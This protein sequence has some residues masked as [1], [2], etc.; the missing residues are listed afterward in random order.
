MLGAEEDV[1]GMTWAG[2]DPRSATMT[3]P[4]SREPS[5]PRRTSH[6]S[7][8]IARDEPLLRPNR[9][10]FAFD[11]GTARRRGEPGRPA[12]LPVPSLAHRAGARRYLHAMP[13][14]TVGP[15]LPMPTDRTPAPGHRSRDRRPIVRPTSGLF[16]IAVAVLGAACTPVE[17]I[18][19]P[20][21][22]QAST[23][24]AVTPSLLK[25]RAWLV[26]SF[27]NATQSAADPDF[28]S[29]DLHVVPIWTSRRDG[30]WLYVEQ[31]VTE[32]PARP[33]RQQVHRLLPMHATNGRDAVT[34][35]VFTL[36]GDPIAFAGAWR[37]P[38]AFDEITPEELEMLEGCGVTF[39]LD[40]LER[41]RGSTL[42][43]NCASSLGDAV[44]ITTEVELF[45][46]RLETLERGYDA[47]G[48]QVWGS[49]HGPYRLDRVGRPSASE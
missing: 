4:K 22:D 47:D 24:T 14:K 40:G 5:E 13:I 8:S 44:Y 7:G 18:D 37:T 21:S 36:P 35:L 2:I 33:Y 12:P 32:A 41:I 9:D 48:E 29:I 38:E 42:G 39:E 45:R 28:R 3:V 20:P 6:A 1:N 26:G 15:S 16:A 27:S 19:S 25:T 17:Q 34:R 11:S 43:R 31:A 10:R 23:P 30:P 46:D 49:E